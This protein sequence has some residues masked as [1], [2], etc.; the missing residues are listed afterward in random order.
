AQFRLAVATFN[1]RAIRLYERVGFRR[2]R[3]YAQETNGATYEFQ[4]M[5]AD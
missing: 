1:E 5:V 4:E 3:T 2:T